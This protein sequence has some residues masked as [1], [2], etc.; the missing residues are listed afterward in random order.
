MTVVLWFNFDVE[1]ELD[2]TFL[3]LNPPV[4]LYLTLVKVQTLTVIHP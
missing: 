3:L 2:Y 4:T 1:P